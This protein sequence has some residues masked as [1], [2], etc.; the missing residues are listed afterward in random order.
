MAD[1]EFRRIRTKFVEKISLPV[2]KQ[3]LDDLLEDGVLNDGETESILN[4]NN[5]RADQARCLADNLRRKGDKACRKMIDHLQE[6]DKTL[7]EELGLAAPQLAPSAIQGP[8]IEAFWKEKMN[9]NSVYTVTKNN[10]R[11]RVALLITNIKFTNERLN[12]QGAEK[13]EENME[14]LLTTLGYEVVKH[15]NLTAEKI[16]KALSEFSKHPKLTE[17]DSVVVVIMSHGKFGAV[18]GVNWKQDDEKP[19]EFPIDKIYTHLAS[20][21]CPA[22]LDKP[23]IIIIQA[24]RGEERGAVLISTDSTVPCVDAPQPG[25]SASVCEENIEEDALQCVHKE[26][27]FISLLSCTPDTVSYRRPD[28]GSFLIQYID[29]IF[30]TR[31]NADDIEELF[32]KVM[33]RFENFSFSNK[34]QMPCK[35]RCTLPKRFYFF[36]GL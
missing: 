30:S 25:P 19:D 15:T 7:Y 20:Q 28:A 18:L 34:R 13:D 26:K 9:D 6:R 17:T 11:S 14:K 33:Q 5:N 31:A 36:P 29:E 35:D 27:D 3:L 8:T 16:D 32:R 12:R 2:L 23:K 24:C 1:K 21:K 22:L 4:E 10:I